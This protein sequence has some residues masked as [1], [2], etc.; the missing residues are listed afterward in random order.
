MKIWNSLILFLWVLEIII[1]NDFYGRTVPYSQHGKL[2]LF[3][4][5]IEVQSVIWNWVAFETSESPK[6]DFSMIFLQY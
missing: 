1:L 4:I 5:F 3:P 2:A 6:I